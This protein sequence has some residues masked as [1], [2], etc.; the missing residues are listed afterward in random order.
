MD[1]L[2]RLN[3]LR[4]FSKKK[5]KLNTTHTFYFLFILHAT[6]LDFGTLF[7]S[8]NFKFQATKSNI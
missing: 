8:S 6:N 3:Y 7:W 1:G 5:K 2:D 4:I